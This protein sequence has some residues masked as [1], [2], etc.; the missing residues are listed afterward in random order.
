VLCGAHCDTMGQAMAYFDTTVRWNSFGFD[1]NFS[2]RSRDSEFNS[3]PQS[4]RPS[5]VPVVL[6][7]VNFEGRFP[8][9][10]FDS[11]IVTRYGNE[12]QTQIGGNSLIYNDRGNIINGNL[13]FYGDFNDGIF[14][15][16]I[17]DPG[18]KIAPL[19]Q[20]RATRTLADDRKILTEIFDGD[21][22]MSMSRFG[23][24]VS[25]YGGNDFI[26]GRAGNDTLSGGQD[27]DMLI[28][29]QGSDVLQGGAAIDIL[30]GYSGNDRIVG[31]EGQDVIAGNDGNDKLTGG[32]GADAF[33][34]KGRTNT[35]VINDFGRGG[36][37]M[38]LI[39]VDSF[40]DLTISLVKG[41]SSRIAF[42]GNV[43]IVQNTR[44]A[45]ITAGDFIFGATGNAFL[46]NISAAF[47]DIWDYAV[48]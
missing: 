47:F 40:D 7:E 16:G 23:D 28:G 30:F 15:F 20:A 6:N 42:D 17:Y 41:G 43:I 39:G 2:V 37:R 25:S 46:N 5:L 44:P 38:V 27:S 18:I 1:L 45:E 12:R 8:G 3:A 4:F 36:D 21:D 35:D 19:L 24:A 31:G 48:P 34:F 10:N 26:A 33:L 32:A 22:F 9:Y 29:Q 11:A 14:R 13:N